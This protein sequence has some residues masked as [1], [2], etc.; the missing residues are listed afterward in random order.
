MIF[1]Q[2]VENVEIS[3]Q[4]NKRYV[5]NVKSVIGFMMI[6]NNSCVFKVLEKRWIHGNPG[7][8]YWL[9]MRHIDKHGHQC[10]SDDFEW[11][12]ITYTE[13]EYKM[14]IHKLR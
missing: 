7:Y 4:L 13:Y 8:T 10:D 1:C 6:P 12:K 14:L 5:N 2:I 3:Y 9:T 11:S